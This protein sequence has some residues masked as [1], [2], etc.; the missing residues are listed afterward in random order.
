MPMPYDL[1]ST[2]TTSGPY[3]GG[4]FWS[5]SFVRG[6][7]GH[8]YM[9]LAH[10]LSPKVAG[11]VGSIY[12]AAVLDLTDP[13]ST[14]QQF[15]T[16][17]NVS[18]LFN[19][20]GVFNA[21]YPDFGFGMVD[22]ANPLG[23]MRAWSS[24]ANISFDLTWEMSSPVILNGGLGIFF[25]GNNQSAVGPEWSV[26][27]C[28]TTGWVQD[29]DGTRV[30]VETESSLTWYDREWGSTPVSWTWFALH[31]TTDPKCDDSEIVMSSWVWDDSDVRFAT[32]REGARTLLV[33]I[34]N[35]T[36]SGEKWTSPATNRTYDL[37]WG[38]HM[39]DGTS[40]TITALRDDQE[41]TDPVGKSLSYEGFV[42]VEGKY[43]DGRPLTGWGL[44]EIAAGLL[45]STKG[46][47]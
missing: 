7:N 9:V 46:T 3:A 25:T 28:T 8:N 39:A 34:S 19:A 31:L 40:L 37:G 13:S 30:A 14:F 45:T 35:V 16:L 5:S 27:A 21:S 1:G 2:H 22:S 36:T 44:V 11:P 26:P 12:R 41:L 43:F 29:T 20:D 23:R 47:K 38:V 32:I 6:A 15:T 18:S 17:S 33:P 10:T 24:V 4:S 42:T